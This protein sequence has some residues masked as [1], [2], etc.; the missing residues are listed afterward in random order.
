MN[1]IVIALSFLRRDGKVF[2]S[3]GCATQQRLITLTAIFKTSK[4]H[5]G[6]VAEDGRGFKGYID[7]AV[8]IPYDGCSSAPCTGSLLFFKVNVFEIKYQVVMLSY[9]TKLTTSARN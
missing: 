7:G 1:P 5:L 8:F 3:S 2:H 4:I 9:C 6:I